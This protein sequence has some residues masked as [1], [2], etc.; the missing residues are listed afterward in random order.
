M[1]FIAILNFNLAVLGDVPAFFNIWLLGDQF[2][3]NIHSCL[4][5]M[6]Q[7]AEK[8]E[9]SVPLYIQDY[10][11]VKLLCK[12]ESLADFSLVRII[13]NLTAALNAKDARLP[14][15]LVV[16]ADIDRVRDIPDI[17]HEDANLAVAIITNWFVRQINM[18]I[19]RKQLDIYE[20]KPGAVYGETKIVFVKMMRRIWNYNENSTTNTLL[21]LKAKFN[22]SLNDAVTKV[23]QYILTINSCLNYEDFDHK[24]MLSQKGKMAFSY[25]IDELI[26]KFC[27]NKVKLLPNPKNPPRSRPRTHHKPRLPKANEN[28]RESSHDKDWRPRLEHQSTHR[29]LPTP[30]PYRCY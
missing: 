24:G 30:P 18:V 5:D 10:F 29:K 17:F 2:L 23:D 27:K 7:E 6:M 16:I 11:N 1:Q 20:K 9:N 14:K 15:I 25:E 12:D 13:N 28:R 8:E 3:N 19:R 4:L 22:D 21:L 26:E